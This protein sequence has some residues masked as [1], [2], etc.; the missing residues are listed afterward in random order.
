MNINNLSIVTSIILAQCSL[1]FLSTCKR[2]LNLGRA[3]S[4]FFRIEICSNSFYYTTT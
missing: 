2:H 3:Q 1:A 4:Q